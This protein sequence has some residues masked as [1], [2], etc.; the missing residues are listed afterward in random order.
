MNH[1]LQLSILT[2]LSTILDNLHFKQKLNYI[3]LLLSN[4]YYRISVIHI[5][6]MTSIETEQSINTC[7]GKCNYNEC[8]R[9]NWYGFNDKAIAQDTRCEYCTQHMRK[10]GIAN[11]MFRIGEHT[12]IIDCDSIT[13]HRLTSLQF[14]GVTFKV[15]SSDSKKPFLVHPESATKRDNGVLVVEMPEVADYIIQLD[16]GVQYNNDNY[17]TF[18]MK[19]GDKPVVINNGESIFYKNLTKVTGF[20]TGSDES[21][22]FVAEEKRGDFANESNINAVNSNIITIVVKKYKRE[23]P[24]QLYSNNNWGGQSYQ[25]RGQSRG[26]PAIASSLLIGSSD[27][28]SYG[29]S[30]AEMMLGSS[31]DV[32]LG[33]SANTSRCPTRK[34]KSADILEVGTRVASAV[35]GGSTVSG[36]NQVS[37]IA[38]QTTTDKF[39]LKDT[40]TVTIQLVHVKNSYSSIVY[41]KIIDRVQKQLDEQSTLLLSTPQQTIVSNNIMEVDDF[42]QV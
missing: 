37:K 25:S 32:M 30:S 10:L 9:T 14:K 8:R 26:V 4:T 20:K 33:S 17:Y 31:A 38:T 11:N 36:H 22:R 13:D 3:I 39:D 5:Y 21:F 29:S 15:L 12:D 1:H 40:F 7:V 2:F 28:E 41:T 34:L 16:Q 18:D 6:K 19:V 42:E 23:Q 27:L 35:T 24:Y